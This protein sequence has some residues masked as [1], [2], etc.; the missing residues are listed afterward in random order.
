MLAARE[1]IESA[2]SPASARVFV[3]GAYDGRITFYSQQVRG[4]ALAHALVDQQLVQEGSRVCVVGG[5]AA[6]MAVA[7]AL[8]LLTTANVDLI[9]RSEQLLP[10]QSAARRRRLD[11]HIYQWPKPGSADLEAEI[12][13]LDWTS[14]PAAEVQRSVRKQFEALSL[15]LDHLRILRSHEVVGSR[16]DG[17][18]VRLNIHRALDVGEAPNTEDGRISEE[19]AY[20]LAVLAFGFGAE[21]TGAV[22]GIQSRTYWSDTGIPER[23]IFGSAISRFLISGNG[24]GG[25]IDLVAAGSADFDHAGIIKLITQYSGI[26]RLHSA[27]LQIEESARQAQQRGERF[28][29]L[30]SYDHEIGGEV[31]TMGLLRDIERRLRPGVHLILQTR[32][33][34]L[35]NAETS[36][37]NRLAAYLTIKACQGSSQAKFEH[38]H[39][40]D[41]VKIATPAGATYKA[42]LWF[43]C[44][45]HQFGVDEAVIRRGTDRRGIRGPFVDLLAG[46][47]DA[48]RT[49][50]DQAGESASVPSLSEK[51][52][53]AILAAARKY[54]IAPAPHVAARHGGRMHRQV[55][56]QSYQGNV[57]WS[58]DITSAQAELLWS[59]FNHNYTIMVSDPPERVGREVAVALVRLALHSDRVDISAEAIS[60]SNFVRQLT[61]SSEHMDRLKSPTLSIARTGASLRNVANMPSKNLADAINRRLNAYVLTRIHF[62]LEG[63]LERGEDDGNVVGFRAAKDLRDKMRLLWDEWRVQL[64]ADVALLDRFLTLSLCAKDS[65]IYEHGARVLVGPHL[66]NAIIKSTAAALAVGSAWPTTTPSGGIPGNLIRKADPVASSGHVCAA[67][68]IDRQSVAVM[69]PSYGWSSA[70]VLLSEIDTPL[71]VAIMASHGFA[72]LR[73]AQPKFTELSSA[74]GVLLTLDQR[75]RRAAEQGLTALSECLDALKVE[76]VSRMTSEVIERG[77]R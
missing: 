5:G 46:Y 17:N 34:N 48:H 10:L 51:G 69:A 68:L 63:F 71:Q 35:L 64:E 70:F 1:I 38:I 58:G 2:Q 15:E 30:S 41:L 6:G 53:E 23:N 37:L 14:G 42:E 57:R 13:I 61:N 16:I 44:N 76:H 75:F 7:A 3:V 65:E 31:E 18:L 45:G 8:A 74:P 21:P 25:L 28:D 60:W 67:R 26:E 36:I 20:D 11:P 29:Y 55:R 72:E 24:D 66:V 49:W 22:K 77:G 39:G 50:C 73:G 47:E 62:G 19:R 4:L 40:P 59:D 54:G 12:P 33:A 32:D 43:E 9:E 56:V 27:L 52:H